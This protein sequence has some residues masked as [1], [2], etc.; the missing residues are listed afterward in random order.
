MFAQGV[1]GVRVR[2]IG[3]YDLEA[4]TRMSTGIA[5]T[6]AALWQRWSEA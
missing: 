3:C 6:V 1:P 5:N 2:V 4:Q